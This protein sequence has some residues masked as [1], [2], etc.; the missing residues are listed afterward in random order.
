MVHT[1]LGLRAF[2]PL[3]ILLL[4]GLSACASGGPVTGPNLAAASPAPGVSCAPFARQLSGI[5]LHGEAYVWWNEAGRLYARSA[6]PDVGA[7]L[8][9]RRTSRLPS[10]H[11][12]VVSQ[13]LGAR[14]LLVIQANWMPG[15]LTVDQLVVD[16]SAR[17]DWTEV[18]MWWPPTNRLGSHAYAAYGFILPP[19]PTTHE[20]LLRAA[21]PAARLALTEIVPGPAAWAD[22]SGG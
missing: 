1:A 10:G 22:G 15:E 2:R 16:V 4:A 11:V 17:N 9:L 14:Q 6:Q 20:A 21:R 13:L 18:R 5:G 3:I 12:A 7:V 8:V 19:Q